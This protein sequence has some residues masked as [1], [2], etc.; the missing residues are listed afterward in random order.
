MTDISLSP[1][2]D[3]IVELCNAAT[4]RGEDLSAQEI[5]DIVL[6]LHPG[7]PL[8]LLELAFPRAA[9]RLRTEAEQGFKEAD[10]LERRIAA[11]RAP[12]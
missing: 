10:A 7:T 9:A 12:S 11:R 1:I 5:H 2:V 8:A 4:E 6:R 3:T